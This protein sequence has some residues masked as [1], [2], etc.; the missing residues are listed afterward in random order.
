MIQGLKLLIP[1][2]NSA[3]NSALCCCI[4]VATEMLILATGSKILPRLGLEPRTTSFKWRTLPSPDHGESLVE[5]L[6]E[7]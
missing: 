2:L 4:F 1:I 3:L 6:G 5:W 7:E